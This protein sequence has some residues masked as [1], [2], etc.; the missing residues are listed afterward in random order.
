MNYGLL[1]IIKFRLTVLKRNN[2]K[3]NILDKKLK[4]RK[5]DKNDIFYEFNIIYYQKIIRL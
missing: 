5:T 3:P 1:Y 2:D 4:T